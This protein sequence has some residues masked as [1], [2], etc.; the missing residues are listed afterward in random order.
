MSKLIVESG[1]VVV[2]VKEFNSYVPKNFGCLVMK[3]KYA[4][5]YPL[6]TTPQLINLIENF[7]GVTDPTIGTI[8]SLVTKKESLTLWHLLQLVSSENRFLVFDKL[9]E[10][11]PAPN[12]VTKE[13]IQGLNKDML[14]NW[15]LEIELKMD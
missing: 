10:F 3:G 9:D 13:G 2:T 5:P 15:R 7:S 12:G 11:V 6:D 4:I 8:L 1:W 14:S